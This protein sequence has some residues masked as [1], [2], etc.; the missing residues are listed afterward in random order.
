MD[1]QLFSPVEQTLFDRRI[2]QMSGPVSSRL[3]FKV[4]KV[5]LAMDAAD[6]K[7]PIWFFIDSPGGEIH[8]GFGIFDTIRFISSPVTTIVSGLAASMGSLIALAAPKER[9]WAFPNAKLLIHQPLI[10][11]V[12]QG[13]ASDLEIHAKDILKTK[14]R[15]NKLYAEETGRPLSQIQELTDRDRWLDVEEA[16]ELGLISKVIKHHKDIPGW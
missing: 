4:K 9:R 10:S 5:L 6:S 12:M 3:A 2:I 11:G 1:I 15:I 13:P 7:K 14:D 8:S 16:K